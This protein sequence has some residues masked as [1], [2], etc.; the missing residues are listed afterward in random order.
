MNL[1]GQYNII[2]PTLETTLTQ[3]LHLLLIH[4]A[5]LYLEENIKK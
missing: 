4:V 2:A 5:S 1:V 3:E